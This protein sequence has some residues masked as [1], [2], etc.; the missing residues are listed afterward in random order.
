MSGAVVRV[1]SSALFAVA[2]AEGRFR[3][4]GIPAGRHELRVEH[5]ILDT[6][7]I[8]LRSN[9]MDFAAGGTTAHQFAAPSPETLVNL[10]CAP[11]WR[12]RGPAALMGRV[13]EADAGTPARGAKVSLV[14]YELDVVG[15]LKRVPRVR[16]AVVGADGTY[17]LCGLPAELDG[18]VQVLRG[19]LTSGEIA[20]SFGQD[21]LFLRSMSIAT[22]GAVVR[23]S[24]PDADTQRASG[25]V[26]SGTAR[27]TGR[28]LNR[29]GAPLVGA[30]VQLAGTPRAT[31]T[32][33]GGEFA[34]DSLPPGTQSVAVRL[35]GYAP[36][37]KAVDLSSASPSSV[38]IMLEDFVPVLETVRVSAQ[39]DRALDDVGFTRRK[40]TGLGFYMD[41]DDLKGRD[42]QHFSDILRSAPGLRVSQHNGRQYLQSARNPT[43]GCV[44]IYI[45]GT[46]WQ[47]M[48]PGDIDDFVKPHEV[49]AI[50]V[51]SPTSTP[52]EYQ[53]QG[54]NCNTIV[55]WTNRK[56]ERKR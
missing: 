51:Y 40:R 53:S 37:E 52:A 41:P 39:R 50:E 24:A 54:A 44:V 55:A 21:I 34:L 15:S 27:L 18:K 31:S 26:V 45:D 20:V 17:R 38:T 47:Q 3:L 11:A 36:V 29:S 33:G 8:N 1:D 22:P 7:G 2:D 49:A 4:E 28:V 14:W 35:L 6:L 56:L 10:T 9:V 48:E 13:R 5:P 16:E 19:P 30:R 23:T 43:G 12:A 42:A 46:M 32:R 25:T